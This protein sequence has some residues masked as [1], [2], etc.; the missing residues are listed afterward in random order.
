[1]QHANKKH[2]LWRTYF[3]GSKR[4]KEKH[5][6]LSEKEPYV[7]CSLVPIN[8]LINRK[9]EHNHESSR[10]RRKKES[11]QKKK[12]EAQRVRQQRQW[13]KLTAVKMEMVMQRFQ[14]AFSKCKDKDTYTRLKKCSHILSLLQLFLR[15]G[16]QLQYVA[17]TTSQ[18]CVNFLFAAL[19]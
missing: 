16:Y 10:S 3:Y 1:M 12:R 7:L 15:A 5:K 14:C 2:K 19:I 17:I 8:I 4:T 13:S 6:G 11:A 18:E 9:P